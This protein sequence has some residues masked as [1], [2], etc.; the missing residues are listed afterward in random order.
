MENALRNWKCR[1]CGRANKTAVALDGTAKC[2]FCTYVMSVQPSR[3][4][5]GTILPASYP[6][7]PRTTPSNGSFFPDR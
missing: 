5:G 3:I 4:K 1:N 7:G 6:T 2:E